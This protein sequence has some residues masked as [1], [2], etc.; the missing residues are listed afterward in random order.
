[1]CASIEYFCK[2]IKLY[3]TT[4]LLN[5]MIIDV[6]IDITIYLHNPE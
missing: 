1:M 3:F 5:I 4:S 6:G 2:K